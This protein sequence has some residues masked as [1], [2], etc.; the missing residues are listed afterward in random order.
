M[1]SVEAISSIRRDMFDVGLFLTSTGAGGPD[2]ADQNTLHVADLTKIVNTLGDVPQ[3]GPGS[4][5]VVGMPPALEGHLVVAMSGSSGSGT[6]TLADNL[7]NPIAANTPIWQVLQTDDQILSAIINAQ[8]HYGT[9]RPRLVRYTLDILAN[10]D[11]YT[12][13]S[14]W[15]EPDQESLDQAI[16]SRSNASAMGSYYNFTYDLS[17]SYALTGFGSAI[18]FGPS[19]FYQYS[20]IFGDINDNPN[21]GIATNNQPLVLIFQRETPPSLVVE[22]MPSGDTSWDIF[23]RAVYPAPTPTADFVV[24]QEDVPYVLEWAKGLRYLALAATRAGLSSLKAGG[25]EASYVKSAD[26]YQA[27]AKAAFDIFNQ[28]LRDIPFAAQG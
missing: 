27:L 12:L 26:Q 15:I 11:T 24:R 5:I 25:I 22:P 20:P 9:Y 13:P 3:V 6:V 7:I 1:K 21:S 8:T 4:Y 16:G 2:A 19:A 14:D 23:Y 10:Q 18:T 28:N 17:N